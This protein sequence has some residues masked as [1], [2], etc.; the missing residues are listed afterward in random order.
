[1][2]GLRG[3]WRI[4]KYG[5]SGEMSGRVRVVDGKGEKWMDK[6]RYSITSFHPLS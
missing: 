4:L 6:Q 5:E 1:V 3:K 2:K